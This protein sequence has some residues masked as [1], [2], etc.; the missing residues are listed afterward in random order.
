MSDTEKSVPL[1][2]NDAGRRVDSQMVA[3]L[4]LVRK[5][6]VAWCLSFIG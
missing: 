5:R 1:R 2:P 4:E 3:A 6:A